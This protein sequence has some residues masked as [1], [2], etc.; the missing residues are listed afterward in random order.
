MTLKEVRDNILVGPDDNL[1]RLKRNSQK[2]RNFGHSCKIV[3]LSDI[4]QWAVIR[5]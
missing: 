1:E 4:K 5:A 2:L 3:Y